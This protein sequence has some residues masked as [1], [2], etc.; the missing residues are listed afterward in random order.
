MIKSIT[1]QNTEVTFSLSL[2]KGLSHHLIQFISKFVTTEGRKVM[3]QKLQS[4]VKLKSVLKST[5]CQ[6]DIQLKKLHSTYHSSLY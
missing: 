3:E 1:C 2:L 6:K 4:T 5:L